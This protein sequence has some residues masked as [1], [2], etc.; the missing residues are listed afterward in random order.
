MNSSFID[1]CLHNK[2]HSHKYQL[3]NSFIYSEESDFFS[4]TG[5]GY[6]QEVEIKISRSDFKADFK[7]R[8]HE[9]FRQIYNGQGTYCKKRVYKI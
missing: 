4:V 8:K 2:F 1:K 3:S 9:D 5:A 6:A 7:K